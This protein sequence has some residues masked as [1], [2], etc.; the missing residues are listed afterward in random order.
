MTVL[1]KP[2]PTS[3]ISQ[4]HETHQVDQ[5]RHQAEREFLES[6]LARIQQSIEGLHAVREKRATEMRQLLVEVGVAAAG[7]LLYRELDEDRFAIEEMVRDIAGHLVNDRPVEIQLN[8]KDFHLMQRRLK[9]RLLFPDEEK[10]PKVVP[11]PAVERGAC[12][13]AG[14]HNSLAH[15]PVEE[16]TRIRDEMLE[17]IVHART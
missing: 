13:V 4:K 11:N 14:E 15:D 9:Q 5:A 7:R 10:A 12:V 3:P 2:E 6:A 8:P 17:R 1:P 16:L